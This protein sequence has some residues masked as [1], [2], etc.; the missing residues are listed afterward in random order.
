[1]PAVRMYWEK[2]T[3]YPPVT[4]VMRRNR[5]HLL[6]SVNHF[7]DN[8]TVSEQ[9]DRDNL[10]KIGPF[11]DIFQDQWLQITPEEHQSTDEMMIPYRGKF[12]QIRQNVRGKP[13]PWGFKVWARCSVHR[14]LH[15]LE[16]YQGKDGDN[17]QRTLALE[18][19]LS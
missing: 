8:E 18:E 19:M 10:W 11:P 12:G 6:L 1:M 7:V 13:Y 9:T 17:N 5:F 3:R 15:D 4:E 16:Y 2:E 14:L